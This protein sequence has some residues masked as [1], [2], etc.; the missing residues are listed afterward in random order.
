MMVG[1]IQREEALYDVLIVGA[2]MA[3]LGAARTLAQAG[4]R[5]LLL[6]AQ[7]RLG[8]RILT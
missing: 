7:S 2:G 5:V 6:E 8:G 1:N 3:G 4:Q